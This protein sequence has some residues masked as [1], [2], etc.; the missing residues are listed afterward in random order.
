VEF[1]SQNI[2]TKEAYAIPNSFA[3]AF[4][5]PST[6]ARVFASITIS[7]GHGRVKPSLRP[8]TRRVNSHLRAVIRQSRS[9]VERI[10]R[11]QRELNVALRINVIEDLQSYIAIS[12]TSTS[13]STTMMH[14]VNIAWP[15]DQMAF[16]TL[17][18][19]PG[20]DLRMETIIRL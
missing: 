10:H 11:S 18:A 14:L 13:S 19:C 1:D 5:F 20:Y 12:C 7:S 4:H 3:S 8:L 2:D 16:M 6:S 15:S 17:R 9:V